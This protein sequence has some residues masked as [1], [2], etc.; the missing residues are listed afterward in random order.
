MAEVEV[1]RSKAL[2]TSTE[3]KH[4]TGRI[5]K[6][7]KNFYGRAAAEL[8]FSERILRTFTARRSPQPCPQRAPSWVLAMTPYSAET[9][10]TRRIGRDFV[11]KIGGRSHREAWYVL[12]GGYEHVFCSREYVFF[13]TFVILLV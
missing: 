10:C 5:E 13:S 3:T 4:Y 1:R 12:V 8:S 9:P 7:K 11:C 2:R 6:S